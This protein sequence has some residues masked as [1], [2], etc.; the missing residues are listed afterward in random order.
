[1]I[2]RLHF[3]KFAV[4]GLPNSAFDGLRLFRVFSTAPGDRE[5]IIQAEL[6]RLMEGDDS[7]PKNATDDMKYAALTPKKTAKP[8]K[9][10]RKQAIS[11]S[12]MS[13]ELPLID[14]AQL[15]Q[16]IHSLVPEKDNSG[17]QFMQAQLA[18]VRTEEAMIKFATSNSDLLD[19]PTRLALLSKIYDIYRLKKRSGSQALL[20]EYLSSPHVAPVFR[21]ILASYKDL[22]PH[23]LAE[24]FT[25]LAKN[26]FRNQEYNSVVERYLYDAQQ[27]GSAIWSDKSHYMLKVLYRMGQAGYDL[28]W[29][30]ADSASKLANKIANQTEVTPQRLVIGVYYYYKLVDLLKQQSAAQKKNASEMADKQTPKSPQQPDNPELANFV[31]ALR[32]H[33]GSL[34]VSQLSLLLSVTP[35]D[36]DKEQVVELLGLLRERIIHKSKQGAGKSLDGKEPN[37]L[38][39][40]GES[41]SQPQG[42][43]W[44]EIREILKAA[45]FSKCQDA[46]LFEEVMSEIKRNLVLLEL[47][48]PSTL[49]PTNTASPVPAAVVPASIPTKDLLLVMYYLVRLEVSECV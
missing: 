4:R 42:L 20:D 35:K 31:R 16:T 21:A 47:N 44:A 45:N 28:K 6:D 34:E 19:G 33:L 36:A 3:V 5:S 14:P 22:S 9:L 2:R 1:M 12:A 41:A 7:V 10:S 15:A 25:I 43:S 46:V 26:H 18:A 39:T 29:F 8:L 48:Q 49:Q 40:S 30:T 32:P 38:K 11:A 37:S 27:V 13:V 24:L 23:D 17:D